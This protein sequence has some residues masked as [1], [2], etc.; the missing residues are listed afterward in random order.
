[1]EREK[2][3]NPIKQKHSRKTFFS[4]IYHHRRSHSSHSLAFN[5]FLNRCW[6]FLLLFTV[7]LTLCILCRFIFFAKVSFSFYTQHDTKLS[8]V[9]MRTRKET[10]L[11]PI[12]VPTFFF[13][14][15]RR[16]FITI[17]TISLSYNHRRLKAH[18]TFPSPTITSR[19]YQ[20]NRCRLT[21]SH[22]HCRHRSLN[23]ILRGWSMES[24]SVERWKFD[25]DAAGLW[26]RM[27]ENDRR[28]WLR[29]NEFE[30]LF[31]PHCRHW[32]LCHSTSSSFCFSFTIIQPVSIVD[33]TAIS[34]SLNSEHCKVAPGE[35]MTKIDRR[36]QENG[37]ARRWASARKSKL[38]FLLYWL[39]T[40]INLNFFSANQM[41]WAWRQ[42][43]RWCELTSNFTQFSVLPT[44][45]LNIKKFSGSF[46]S[47][48][49]YKW[50]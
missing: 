9:M 40:E 48:I 33:L 43:R 44:W 45:K 16:K 29:E 28:R 23:L 31:L 39:E 35:K 4:S 22:K 15:T 24:N 20:I 19:N 2:F 38:N 13:K 21:A 50:G 37:K 41:N 49:V 47:L 34:I 3:P 18:K 27:R 17:L 26:M 14:I 30:L 1:M 5:L 6:N 46:K 36:H 11:C 8:I 10:I 32:L 25:A 7:S 42:W 12:A